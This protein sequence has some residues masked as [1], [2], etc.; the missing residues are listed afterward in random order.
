LRS[1]VVTI[2]L[3]PDLRVGDATAQS[4]RQNAMGLVEPQ[5]IRGQV[6]ALTHQR[7]GDRSYCNGQD[8]QSILIMA[9]TS[10]VIVMVT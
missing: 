6:A 4:D 3:V 5:G 10:K 8:R 9:S 7:Q 2:F 1:F